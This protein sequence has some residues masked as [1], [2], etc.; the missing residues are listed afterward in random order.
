MKQITYLTLLAVSLSMTLPSCKSQEKK[1]AEL[2]AKIETS[3]PGM[4]V[5]VKG[6]V[7]T[8]SGVASDESTKSNIVANVK[9]IKGVSEVINNIETPAPVAINPDATLV[10][11]VNVVLN[12]FPGVAASVNDGVVTLNGEIKR[13]DLPNLIQLINE[14]SP[15]KVENKLTI[16]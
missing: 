5:S 16:K 7:A 3:A 8:I 11:A 9:N 13:S 15:R 2:K 6:G 10:G 4:Q 14:L 12:N 1:D